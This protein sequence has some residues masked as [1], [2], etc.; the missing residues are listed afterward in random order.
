MTL[1]QNCHGTATATACHRH[2]SAMAM[3]WQRPVLPLCPSTAVEWGQHCHGNVI[4]KTWHRHGTA[5]VLLWHGA[6]VALRWGGQRQ[7][8]GIAM[9]LLSVGSPLASCIRCDSAIVMV[10]G[11]LCEEESGTRFI[12]FMSPY[13]I[14][15][16]EKWM[17]PAQRCPHAYY[18]ANHGSPNYHRITAL[19]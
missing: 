18:T 12:G 6:H 9:A 17:P 15:L 1:L 14:H 16:Q 5:M 7:F 13:S 4:S 3:P 2:S 19:N 8:H 10:A 11:Q